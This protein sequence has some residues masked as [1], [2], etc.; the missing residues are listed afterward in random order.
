MKYE[1]GLSPRNLLSSQNKTIEAVDKK[2]QFPYSPGTYFVSKY[3]NT[4]YGTID[5][6]AKRF[7]EIKASPGPMDYHL[8]DIDR[9]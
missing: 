1:A 3:R 9:F 5:P 7:P 4:K 2:Q 6:N 8:D